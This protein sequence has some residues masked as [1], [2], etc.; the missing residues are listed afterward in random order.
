MKKTSD[1][2]RLTVLSK[3]GG[4]W[5]DASILCLRPLTELLPATY[6]GVDFVGYFLSPFTTLPSSPVIESWFF[7]AKK[8]CRFV[9]LWAEE[10]TRI[11]RFETADAYVADVVASG[12][13]LQKIDAPAYLAIH[14]AAQKVLQK[15]HVDRSTLKLFDAID[16]PLKYL[17]NANWD[18]KSALESLKDPR[19]E[20]RRH[21]TIVKM[22][23]PERDIL[24]GFSPQDAA[25]VLHH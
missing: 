5:M 3:Y 17:Y 19:S 25:L 24:T 1:L 15:Q 8:G 18:S 16:G 21:V 20:D 12:V 10:F 2:V 9:K 22:R 4:V 13:D 6:P 7:A 11:D 23:G 14:V